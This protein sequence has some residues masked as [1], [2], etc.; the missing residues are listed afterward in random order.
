M[1]FLKNMLGVLVAVPLG[2]AAIAGVGSALTGSLSGI[3]GATQ[4]LVATGL[5]GKA[6]ETSKGLFK[7]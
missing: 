4:T 2:G 3:G 1:E 6:A 7:F 5:L